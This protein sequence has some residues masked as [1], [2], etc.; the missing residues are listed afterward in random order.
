MSYRE[1]LDVFERKAEHLR[2]K[3]YFL[4]NLN[5]IAS[6]CFINTFKFGTYLAIRHTF[7]A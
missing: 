7:K 2:W 6:Q 5:S 1:T 4:S 3:S